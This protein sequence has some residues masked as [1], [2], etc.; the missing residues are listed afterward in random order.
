M[1]DQVAQVWCGK[2]GALIKSDTIS[3]NAFEIGKTYLGKHMQ[4]EQLSRAASAFRH[5]WQSCQASCDLEEVVH[6]PF[7]ETVV[8]AP[9]ALALQSLVLEERILKEPAAKRPRR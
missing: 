2:F 5:Y 8:A 7:V 1:G 4:G 9:S 6:N 3:E